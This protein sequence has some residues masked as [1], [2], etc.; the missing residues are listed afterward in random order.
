MSYVTARFNTVRGFRRWVQQKAFS[1]VK[2]GQL[3]VKATIS[4]ERITGLVLPI[5]KR[6]SYM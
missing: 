5:D 6:Q 3:T 1:L 2:L 4:Y